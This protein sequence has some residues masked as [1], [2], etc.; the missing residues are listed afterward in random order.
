MVDLIFV[1]GL[2]ASGKSSVAQ[3]L[4]EHISPSVHL[5]GDLF[6]RMIVQGQAPMGFEL[7]KQ[8]E[9]QLHLRYQLAAQSASLYREAGFTVVY[10]DI[11]LGPDLEEVVRLHAKPLALV[12]LCPQAYVIAEREAARPKS[13][14]SSREEIL[15]FDRILRTETPKIGY[16][17]DTTDLSLSESVDAILQNLNAAII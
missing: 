15:A 16:W 1:T 4:A 3:A 9:Q 13:G 2:M 17:L 12:V 8:A 7:S 6:R 10:Q 5:R 14:Y 11:V